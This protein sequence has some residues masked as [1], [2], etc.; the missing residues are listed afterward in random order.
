M[1]KVYGKRKSHRNLSFVYDF[2]FCSYNIF[3]SFHFFSFLLPLFI[4]IMCIHNSKL[5]QFI[6]R[7]TYSHTPECFRLQCAFL[8]GPPICLFSLLIHFSLFFIFS[9]LFS[10]LLL[11]LFHSFHSFRP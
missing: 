4:H 6:Y 11:L 3:T 1:L 2:T 10:F 8:L 5:M 9:F 7:V